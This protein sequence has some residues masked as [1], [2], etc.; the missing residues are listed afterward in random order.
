MARGGAR[1]GD[2]AGIG[3]R[4]R[5]AGEQTGEQITEYGAN[6]YNRAI[7]ELRPRCARHTGNVALRTLAAALEKR[8]DVRLGYL[9][10][11]LARGTAR[12]DSDI[13]VALS[14]GRPMTSAEKIGLIGSIGA[15]FGRPVDLIDMEVANGAI[16][17]TVFQEGIRFI[18]DV[19]VR[20]RAIANRA[21]WQTDVAPYV[22]CLRAERRTGWLGRGQ[23]VA[24]S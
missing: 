13:D 5:L 6:A 20:E 14:L 15:L 17:G 4:D 1:G 9:F 22:E 8:D 10:G 23:G 16:P 18:D 24:F 2:Q 3:G 11:S 19:R 12:T 7:M 21:N